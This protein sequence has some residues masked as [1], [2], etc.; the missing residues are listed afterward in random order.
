MR[1]IISILL[2]L[3]LILSAQTPQ[4]PWEK[5]QKFEKKALPKSALKEVRAIYKR[6]KQ[7]NNES[8]LIKALLYREKLQSNLQEEGYLAAIKDIEKEI[9]QS[10]KPTSKL[11]L[12][13]IL[14]Q[15]Y[16]N[17]VETHRYKLQERSS[18]E[19]NSSQDIQIW[20]SQRLMQKAAQLYRD[21]LGK[22]AQKVPIH[23]YQDI[24]L[25]AQNSEGLRPTL[26]DFLAFRALN[27]FTN[28]RNDLFQPKDHFFIQE[29][30]AFGSIKSFIK[31]PFK[32]QNPHAF[33]Y[34][35]L[36]IYQKLL[37]FHQHTKNQKALL[38]INFERLKFVYQ[39]FMG[40][41]KNRYY[42]DALK[43]L[44]SQYTNSEALYYLAHYYFDQGALEKALF[45]A[46]R[47]I[48]SDDKYLAS[49]S[50]A[51]KNRITEQFVRLSIE[52]VNLPNEN[53]LSKISYKNIDHLTIKVIKLSPQAYQHIQSLYGKQRASFI[54]TLPS[55]R[56]FSLSLP[57][58]EDYKEHSTELSLGKYPLGIYLFII[59][60]KDNFKEA[61]SENI[62]TISKIAYFNKNDQLLVLNR[63]SGQPLKGVTARFYQSQYNSQSRKYERKLLSTKKSDSKGIIEKPK[64]QS[65]YRVEFEY[66]D[67]FLSS[68][69][70]LY[71]NK[72]NRED[73]TSSHKQVYLFT[74]RAIY[75]PAQTL[76]FK[77]LAVKHYHASK[78][79]ILTNQTI[80]ISLLDP[81]GEK[82]ATK[83]FKTNDFGTFN[84]TFVLPKQGL[85]GEMHLVV[86][87]GIRGSQS[88]RVEEYKRPKFEINFKKLSKSY[89]L[90][91]RITIQGEAKA[92]AGNGID[93]AKVR[94]TIHRTTYFPWHRW[95][96]PLPKTQEIQI[97]KGEITT[98]ANGEFSIKFKALRDKSIPEEEKPNF[99]YTIA[100]DITDPTGETHSST[101]ELTLGFVA[102][103]A[104][105]IINDQLN[106]NE[107]KR[108]KLQTRNLDGS[109]EP[110]K[111]TLLVEKFKN[112]T[113]IYRKRYWGAIDQPSYSQTEFQKLFNHYA[114][115]ETT[116][117]KSK[118]QTLH[119][120]TKKSK[121]LLLE[122]LD[123]G[124]YL[125]T[126]KTEDR[127]GTKVEKSKKITI[128]DPESQ[129]PPYRTPLWQQLDKTN[130]PVGSTATLTLKSATVNNYAHLS[131]SRGSTIIKEKWIQFNNLSKE[132][133]PITQ[134]DRGDLNYQI[135]FVKDNRNYSQS[136]TIH[137]PWKEQLH[138]EYISFRDK[139]EPNKEEQW[140]IKIS[141]E[142]K[143]NVMAEMVATI[144]DASLD[145]F[146]SHEFVLPSLFPKHHNDYRNQWSTEGFTSLKIQQYWYPN[147]QK[148]VR[149]T[150]HQL[151]WFGFTP[152][153]YNGEIV[154]Y[155]VAM[156][157]P[158]MEA[159][160]S[161]VIPT[162]SSSI[163]KSLSSATS[164][165][166]TPKKKPP[167]VPL[168]IRKNLNG[169][170]FFKPDLRTDKEGNIIINFKTN[171]ALTR[172][173]F[174]GFVH[175]K[176]LRT[177][178]TH[179]SFIT[180]KELMVSSNLPRFFREKDTIILREKIVNMSNHEVNGSCELKLINPLTNQPL[181]P[182]R[183]MSKRF[184]IKANGS[185]VVD[186]KIKIPSINQTPA[187]QHTFIAHSQTH[188][189][190]EQSIVPILSNRRL[191]TQ[192]QLLWVDGKEKRTFVLKA[193]KENN[194]SSIENHR[195]T[196]EFTS[197]PAWYA[198]R[199]LPYLMEYPH[200]CNEQLF[201]RY[202]ANALAKKL[203]NQSP[204]IKNIF[205][206]WKQRGELKSPLSNN[207]KLKSILLAETPWVLD[208]KTQEAQ[209]QNLGL[210]FDLI[211]LAKKEKQTFD[212]L[213]NN[214]NNDGGWA[215]FA[216]GK[217]DWYITQYIVE[218]FGRLKQL[219][220][221]QRDTPA[222]EKALTYLDHKIV[223]AY[224]D[225]EQRV[226]K[227]QAKWEE[228]HLNSRIIHYLYTRSLYA[229]KMPKAT[230]NAYKYYLS[231][232]EQYWSDQPLYE[233]AMIAL[234][235]QE[236]NR[237][238]Y[239]KEII[240]SFKERAITD[241]EQGMYF[242]Y[243]HGLA[244]NQ[245]P[246]ET[247]AMMIEVFE[248]LTHDKNSIQNLKKWL[249]KNKQTN[250]WETTK[251]TTAA[252]YALLSQGEWLG[253]N[254][255]VDISFHGHSN[256]QP[257]LEKAKE[258]AQKGSGYFNVSFEN[259][260][261]NM[262]TITIK[263]PNQTPAW[264]GLYWQYFESLDQIKSSNNS[265]MSI[266]K[267]LYL[268]KTTK[269]GEKLIPIKKNPLHLGDKIKVQLTLHVNRD[270][271][272]IMLKDGR[273]AA[274]EPS[275]VLSQYKWQDGL[276][277]YESTKESASYFFID[278][279]PRGTYLIEY[280]LFVTHKGQFSSGIATLESMYAPAFRSHSKGVKIYVK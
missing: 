68:T 206:S 174:L 171:G 277:Y 224:Q 115:Q 106:K 15:M 8:Q 22:A 170:M 279:L 10:K 103:E 146:V 233:Q 71:R 257:R 136:G 186:F 164:T 110:L 54:K 75:R 149:R 229:Q 126:L 212:Q 23:R 97:G 161:G 253:E 21:S 172:W 102:V 116:Q 255:L 33:K 165:I 99:N 76:Y 26:Y 129:E 124:A 135:N 147:H 178:V 258:N 280:P 12:T 11:I 94:Y 203:A 218:G 266:K 93:N 261:N 235:L 263:N 155:D 232:I 42:L 90:G 243:P 58:Q 159:A 199:S 188:S 209:Q 134:E 3:S 91:D 24:L 121:E 86:E 119:F 65:S 17:Y 167:K 125:L 13:S 66:G 96:L 132:S 144:Y 228:D 215:W 150:F 59:A 100:V 259:F 38:H 44:D 225:L 256:Y 177:A 190:A 152:D 252:I 158:V 141:G 73:Q 88:I 20:D 19:D 138:V 139:L 31:Y 184:K 113:K 128:Y 176:D 197:N 5:V 9:K 239:A 272:Y 179:K 200:E 111:G 154:N 131:I 49:R 118:I 182:D 120:D 80:K 85:L 28:E 173:N 95:W 32:S 189:D 254:Q 207:P 202:F 60:Q 278:H 157:A 82:K 50:E 84:G 205:E 196:L 148:S 30:E 92:Y 192:S 248:H 117:E 180:Q 251:A 163:K 268:V 27:Y 183:N 41:N 227:K 83:S 62:T 47:G 109:F 234:T 193:L 187:I 67:D 52:K 247:H 37:Q 201:G 264:G 185:M 226:H 217:S 114:Y 74:D 160:P 56:T 195:L 245:M 222:L 265:P 6:A 262:S 274:F 14:A 145:A 69:R 133:I 260:D 16:S 77:G 244:W 208:A 168:N 64:S 269:A 275:N 79:K 123:Q 36:L 270:M 104:D 130:Y 48:K 87:E 156:P 29:K 35:A 89:R 127:Y 7:E 4:D 53:I 169:T 250:H 216:G 40:A 162:R 214:Q 39:N 210:L 112:P 236:K 221:D 249:L 98:D 140:R 78:P 166:A 2:L 153:G 223:E 220:I 191:I 34:Q 105:L 107:A 273:A 276:G 81:N 142:K 175:S 230:L 122:G 219:G 70:G 242:K 267:K 108:V 61:N 51:I 25:P 213:I 237:L 181:F 198:L 240:N 45:Y 55:L 204:K 57:K 143:E 151:N 211:Q 43:S 72:N 231:Q 18:V 271:E 246:I 63:E 241:E 1:K 101:K 46:N 194:S 137:V 238:K